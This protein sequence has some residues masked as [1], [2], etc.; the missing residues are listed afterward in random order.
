ME[1]IPGGA[2]GVDTDPPSEPLQASIAKAVKNTT[3]NTNF[4]RWLETIWPEPGSLIARSL[5]DKS[6]QCKPL[7]P[8]T[9]RNYFLAPASMRICS[10]SE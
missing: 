1:N 9:P 4:R 3:P 7:F 5:L 2:V 6:G 8:V 10:I